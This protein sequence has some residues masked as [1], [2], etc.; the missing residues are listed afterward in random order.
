MLPNTIIGVQVQPYLKTWDIKTTS[1]Q[2]EYL[3]HPEKI[4]TSGIRNEQTN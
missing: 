4:G 3:G 2:P 1:G